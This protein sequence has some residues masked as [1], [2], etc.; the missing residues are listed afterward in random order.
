MMFTGLPK[1]FFTPAAAHLSTWS[2][3]GL[4]GVIGKMAETSVNAYAIYDAASFP[5]ILFFFSCLAI[6]IVPP[7]KKSIF[8]PY[9]ITHI[10]IHFKRRLI[11]G[12]KAKIIPEKE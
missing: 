7:Y 5:S 10:Y 6:I 12:K 2:A 1:M 11:Y 4:D 8:Y 3:I 9:N